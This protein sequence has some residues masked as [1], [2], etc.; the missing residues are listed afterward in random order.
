MVIQWH[1]QGPSSGSGG[2]GGVARGLFRWGNFGGEGGGSS[3]AL[4]MPKL[5]RLHH[6]ADAPKVR[7]GETSPPFFTTKFPPKTIP[8]TKPP[9]PP[10]VTFRRV[11]LFLYGALDSHPFVPSHVASGRCVLS[12]AAAG[13]PAGVI[14]AFAE[15][16]GWCA[17]AV[18]DAAGCALR[19]SVPPPPPRTLRPAE[20]DI[21]P[22]YIR[23]KSVAGKANAEDPSP[24]PA[25][26][27]EWTGTGP[28][29]PSH[30]IL[31][32]RSI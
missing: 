27:T 29:R 13:A 2:G 28:S 15:P 1:I 16:S 23:L 25:V 26:G 19:A 7:K 3:P 4:G 8:P 24:S 22:R 17:G 5:Q 10:C 20:F 32:T 30:T 6:T 21:V 14:S 18:L 11:V 12:A 31:E 9:P